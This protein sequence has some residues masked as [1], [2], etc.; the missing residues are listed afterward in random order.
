[1]L[2]GDLMPKQSAG[3]STTNEGL[4]DRAAWLASGRVLEMTSSAGPAHQKD[5]VRRLGMGFLRT[6]V[7]L[8]H[9]RIQH[10]G[11]PYAID[12]G[13]FAASKGRAWSEDEFLAALA[14]VPKQDPLLV[15]TVVPDIVRG[16]MASL[17]ESIAWRDRL[18]E[19][20]GW[21]PFGLAVQDGMEP[22]AVRKE[23]ATGRWAAL[24]VG[25]SKMFKYDTM[26]LWREVA[27]E[28]GLWL[29]G[30]GLG[31]PED[32]AWARARRCNS[33]DYTGWARHDEIEEKVTEGRALREHQTRT[34]EFGTLVR[35]QLATLGLRRSFQ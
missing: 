17:A 6:A 7:P 2:E 19:N 14:K 9:F 29:H 21:M 26:W 28:F 25:G 32:Q 33:I 16:G 35:S 22:D 30:L 11:Q 27:N 13:R 20:Y 3:S 5:A 15:F 31:S 23:L 34:S 12:N 24:C 4:F 18:Q 1:M 10:L 8:K